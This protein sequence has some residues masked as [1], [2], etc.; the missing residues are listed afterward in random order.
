MIPVDVLIRPVT[1]DDIYEKALDLLEK[2][3]IPARS[4][5]DGGVAQ[6]LL[7]VLA[8]LAFLAAQIITSLVRMFFLAYAEKDGLTAHAL[9][10]YDVERLGA[11]FATG[12][13]KLLNKGGAPFTRGKEEVI[14]YSSNTGARF[15]VVGAL[16]E[17]GTV[18]D[19][20][21]LSGG[22]SEDAPIVLL[23]QVRAVDAGAGSSVSPAEIDSFVTPLSPRVSVINEASIIGRDEE[24]DD[25]LRR[26]CAAKKGA[27]STFGPRD[28]Y[29]YAALTA[30]LSDGS[31][32]S[33]SRVWV[34]R[35]SSV[36][37]VDVVCATP[38]G[39]P[40]SEEIAAVVA[41]IERVARPDCVRVV[42]AGAIPKL[43]HHQVTIWTN[44]GAESV[45]RSNAQKALSTF[46]ATYPIGGLRKT[47]GG[48]GYVYADKVDSVIAGSSIEVF[49][50]D[51][52]SSADIALAWN[53]VAVNA[54][55]PDM[56]TVRVR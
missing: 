18:S 29:E 19:G 52:E 56:I 31:P 6:T 47:D 30:K 49:D 48:T 21:T 27:W 46:Y 3:D 53:E 37:R 44:G 55:T 22:G 34:S 54:T 33:V 39:T 11:T 38:A 8:Y 9:D 42:V 35:Y 23:V 40:S 16:A 32:T 36:G 2:V 51:L 5:K 10:V 4:W 50:V 28:A 26:R 7:G 20:F 41:E 1:E 14:V 43:T 12:P 45:I 24:S 25:Q 15:Y 13:A 17:D